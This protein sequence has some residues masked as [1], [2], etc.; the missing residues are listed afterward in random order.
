MNEPRSRGASSLGAMPST[1]ALA[2]ALALVG[3]IGLVADGYQAHLEKL[4]SPPPQFDD[5]HLRVPYRE[6]YGS[7]DPG[8]SVDCRQDVAMDAC[9]L[10]ALDCIMHF[11]E[12]L[13]LLE[14]SGVPSK[15]IG[16]MAGHFGAQVE[17]VQ[18]KL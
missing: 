18:Y 11:E 2:L 7:L 6:R 9:Y 12:S 1:L 16:K 13:A 17:M 5:W 4:S 3:R 8:V 10:L 15:R 14:G